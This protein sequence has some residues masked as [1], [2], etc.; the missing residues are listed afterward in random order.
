MSDHKKAF[1]IY[2]LKGEA[3][4]HR[5]L[6]GA[7][8]ASPTEQAYALLWLADRRTSRIEE[9][10]LGKKIEEIERRLASE[11]DDEADVHKS[12]ALAQYLAALAAVQSAKA[13]ERAQ[14]SARIVNFMALAAILVSIFALWSEG[15][16]ERASIQKTAADAVQAVA[17][18]LGQL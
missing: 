2:D 17:E 4:A 14:S 11:T 16:R 9:R 5:I 1:A 12:V 7:V 8:K 6:S 3:L 15:Q 13:Q 10:E 18:I